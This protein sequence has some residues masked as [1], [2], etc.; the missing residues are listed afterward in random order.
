[1][2]SGPEARLPKTKSI[3][4]WQDSNL[5]PLDSKSSALSI[6]PQGPSMH[7]SS[8]I[9]THASR[10]RLELESSALDR[11]AMKPCLDAKWR[12]LWDSNPR[13]QSP[14]T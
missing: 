2:G 5:Q 3:R 13:G 6:A 12:R 10:W 4:P 9:R 1:M 7:G 14:L 11:S 8:G